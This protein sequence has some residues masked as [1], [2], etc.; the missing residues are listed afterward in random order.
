MLLC[1]G[2]AR[3][4][5]AKLSTWLPYG[6]VTRS[7]ILACLSST[8]VSLISHL[9]VLIG[10]LEDGEHWDEYKERPGDMI[11]QKDTKSNRC[12]GMI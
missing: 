10:Y 8:V 7:Q 5:H 4:M 11:M 1:A 3:Q 12:H 6:G 2:G 9:D